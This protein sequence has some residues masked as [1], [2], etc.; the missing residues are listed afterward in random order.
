MKPVLACLVFLVTLLVGCTAVQRAEMRWGAS[1]EVRQQPEIIA[2]ASD[3]IE[4]L[5]A[6]YADP[7]L[8]AK[9]DPYFDLI[10]KAVQIERLDDGPPRQK[11]E[12]PVTPEAVAVVKATQEKA[13][14]A[15]ATRPTAGDILMAAE[16]DVQEISDAGFGLVEA[17]L[18][19]LT[20]AGV[21]AAGVYRVKTQRAKV[22]SD[23]ALSQV[24]ELADEVTRL[25]DALKAVVEGIEAWKTHVKPAE[26]GALTDEIRKRVP[27][28]AAEEAIDELRG[29]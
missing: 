4:A 16:N 9:T 19:I 22:V 23:A 11:P 1:E 6:A 26:V 17:I 25:N 24:D 29:K 27:P 15:A 18:S 13:A 12:L 3:K 21:T 2:L 20:A 14:V 8:V 7:P 5:V 28:S 10:D